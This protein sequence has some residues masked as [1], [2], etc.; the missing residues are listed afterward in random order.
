MKNSF[1]QVGTS[2]SHY[3]FAYRRNGNTSVFLGHGEEPSGKDARGYSPDVFRSELLGP[4]TKK[5]IP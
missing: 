1:L 2:N 3:K 5:R 4:D